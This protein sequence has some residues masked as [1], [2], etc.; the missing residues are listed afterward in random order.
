MTLDE[1]HQYAEQELSERACRYECR[2]KMIC[3]LLLHA[4]R[5]GK[6]QMGV[7]R[8]RSFIDRSAECGII[9]LTI[10]QIRASGQRVMDNER[11]V[12]STYPMHTHWHL[13]DFW[14]HGIQTCPADA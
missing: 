5:N 4:M 9:L 11:P 7:A 14:I 2:R 12:L 13:S 3:T 6:H 10:E 1:I 8:G